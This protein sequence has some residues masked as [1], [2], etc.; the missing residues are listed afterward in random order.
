MKRIR[1]KQRGHY[2]GVSAARLERAFTRFEAATR[3]RAQEVAYAWCDVDNGV[4]IACD[5]FLLALDQ[6]EETLKQSVEL[7]REPMDGEITE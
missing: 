4:V 6:L 3:R 5:E 7:L 2:L 1:A